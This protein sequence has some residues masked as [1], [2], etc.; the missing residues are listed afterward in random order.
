MWRASHRTWIAVAVTVLTV[1]GGTLENPRPATAFNVRARNAGAYN[2]DTGEWLYAQSIDTQVPVA[3]LTKLAAALTF[4]RLDG[5]LDGTITVTRE[6]WTHVG[7]TRLRPGDR[8]PARTLL[9]LALVSS[10]NCAA[11]ALTHPFGLTY[12]AY[13]YRM[14]ETAHQLGCR[15]SVF[16]EPTGLDERNE[17]TAREVVLLFAAALRH[18]LLREFLGTRKFELETRRGPRTIVHSSRL[19]RARDEILAAK[20]GY[21][22][23]AGYCMVEAVS[24]PGGEFI[25]VVLG[26]PTKR[27]RTWESM[28]LIDH[29]RRARKKQF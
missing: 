16:V 6:D 29:V 11:R 10:D 20:T 2:P 15:N 28:K 12:E 26:A 19:L 3:S 4:L 24:D 8:V 23:E 18:P 9:K 5:D 13:G 27:A 22:D 25:T 17:S 1:L 21:I 7:R 14:Q